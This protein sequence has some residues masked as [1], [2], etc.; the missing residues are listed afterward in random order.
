MFCYSDCYQLKRQNTH[1][2]NCSKCSIVRLVTSVH[3]TAASR[4]C[5]E[6]SI[7]WCTWNHLSG[8]LADS[9]LFPAGQISGQRSTITTNDQRWPELHSPVVWELATLATLHL[10]FPTHLFTCSQF[11][12]LVSVFIQARCI[13]SG[14]DCLIS[15][16]NPRCLLFW[17]LV[18]LTLIACL[19]PVWHICFLD[20][21]LV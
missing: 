1:L 16:P 14:P 17:T 19:L 18:C 11:S 7:L 5:L 21:W 6:K 4:V 9:S 8:M 3:Y 2:K 10:V 12:H 20:Y 15:S 13:P